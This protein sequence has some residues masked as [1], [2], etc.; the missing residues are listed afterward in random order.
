MRV[1]LAA[2]TLAL[3]SMVGAAKLLPSRHRRAAIGGVSQQRSHNQQQPL[4]KRESLR[5]TSSKVSTAN[6]NEP[7][8]G[9]LSPQALTQRHL[10]NQSNDTNVIDL[11]ALLDAEDQTVCD[12]SNWNVLVGSF[13]CQLYNGNSYCFEEYIANGVCGTVSFG[14]DSDGTDVSIEYCVATTKP[15]VHSY[16][17]KYSMSTDGFVSSQGDFGGAAGN[18]TLTV[19][20]DECNA[21]M[22]Q[23]DCIDF[24]GTSHPGPGPFDCSNTAAGTTGNQCLEDFPFPLF[25]PNATATTSNSGG[26]GTNGN[27]GSD[28]GQ[29]PATSPTTETE[30]NGGSSTPAGVE[31]V[32]ENSAAWQAFSTSTAVLAATGLLAVVT[33]W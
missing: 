20:G 31:T 13:D 5:A 9:I 19:D 16:C 4:W 23:T 30:N 10:Q 2:A 18:C 22:I 26:A 27:S 29:A 28:N 8:V 6:H 25:D 7:D 24:N 21:C 11:C 1:E 17:T 33:F 15:S 12:C 3:P 14:V 32:T